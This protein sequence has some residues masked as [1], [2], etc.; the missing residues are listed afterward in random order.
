M[1]SKKNSQKC[2]DES[3]YI[4]YSKIFMDIVNAYYVMVS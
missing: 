2:F 1:V 4:Q 3:R